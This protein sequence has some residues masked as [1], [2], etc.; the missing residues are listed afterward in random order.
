MNAQAP[1]PVVTE[2]PLAAP[3]ARRGAAR[4]AAP[5]PAWRLATL[6]LPALAQ[7]LLWWPAALAEGWP[8]LWPWALAGASLGGLLTA[9]ALRDGAALRGEARL[10]LGL[11]AQLLGAAWLASAGAEQALL[12]LL[13][14]AAGSLV[15]LY[16][17]RLLADARGLRC[18]RRRWP[19]LDGSL[20]RPLPKVSLHLISHDAPPAVMRDTLDRLAELD[21]PA[22]EVLVVDS[23]EAPARWEKVAE[24]VARLGPRFRFFQIGACP[25]AA[26][27]FALRETAPDALAIGL[28][29]PGCRVRPDW[30]RRGMPFLQAR[31]GLGY[32]QAAQAVPG[33][34]AGLAQRLAHAADEGAWTLPRQAANEHCAARLR[35][36]LA[37]I[38]AE[39]LR[40]AGG[41]DAAAP[42]PV[43]ELGLRLLR[44]GWD[45]AA[46]A[47]PMGEAPAQA[48]PPAGLGHALRRH[49]D[50]LFRPWHRGLAVG[51]RR[52]LL[53][54]AL[55]VAAEALWA[56]AALAA[57]AVTLGLLAARDGSAAPLLPFAL[58]AL[59]LPAAMAGRALLLAPRGL[60]GLA[61]VAALAGLAQR[62]PDAAAA[63]LGLSSPRGR[64]RGLGSQAG[65][66]LALALLALPFS[67]G[68][69]GLLAGFALPALAALALWARARRAT[70]LASWRHRAG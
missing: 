18:H 42:E 49:A 17:A 47:E 9:L 2:S 27:G 69:A 44:Q 32:V 22:F 65:T 31:L 40:L 12:W 21:Y 29:E 30:L 33:A 67:A 14:Q 23:S 7:P 19:A 63:L 38:R 61:A 11:L 50:V 45:S 43:A 20:A 8:A 48:V 24:H 70:G 52:H 60:R 15:L 39:A 37:L 5:G 1:H 25:Q 13:L 59:A 6:L 16:Q 56:G 35:P 64:W 57:L 55:Q 41:W 26:R 36:S 3:M 46:L 28:V 51:Q 66:F 62:G 34:E 53:A 10:A 58:L 4:A 54:P 68:W